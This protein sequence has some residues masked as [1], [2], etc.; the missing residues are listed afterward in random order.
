MTIE[1]VPSLTFQMITASPE[2]ST[3]KS[4]GLNMLIG[5]LRLSTM[6]YE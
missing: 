5:G 6:M 2:T 1:M 4:K 3:R